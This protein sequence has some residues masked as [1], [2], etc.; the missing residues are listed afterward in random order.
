MQISF[1]NAFTV[2]ELLTVVIIVGV[3]AVIAIPNFTRNMDRAHEQDIVTQLTTIHAANNVYRAQNGR[4]FPTL[5][6]DGDTLAEI[7]TAF[8]LSIMANGATFTFTPGGTPQQYTCTGS[9]GTFVSTL[10]QAPL[11][12][13]NPNVP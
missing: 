12:S 3:L 2:M 13:S 5:A 8:G 4:Y 1:K 11:S 10:T 7:N 6:S 9:K